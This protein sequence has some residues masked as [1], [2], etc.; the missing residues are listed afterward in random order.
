MFVNVNFNVYTVTRG[1]DP[2][3][4]WSFL[5]ALYSLCRYLHTFI[6]YILHTPELKDTTY[7]SLLSAKLRYNAH[8]ASQPYAT[9]EL[10]EKVVK[11]I[12]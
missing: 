11:Y 3:A 5:S 8:R 10:S 9:G 1:Q 2:Y 4:I 6:L 7:Y 12:E